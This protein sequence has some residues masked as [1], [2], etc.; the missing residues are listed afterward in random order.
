MGEDART[1]GA[2]LVAAL[3]GYAS[4]LPALERA[5]AADD[6]DGV[7]QA[8]ILVRRLRSLLA[9]SR[10]Y[11]A[12]GAADDVRAHLERLG[13]DLGEVRDLEVRIR[14]AE[15]HVGVG[16]DAAAVERLIV[17]ERARYR[18]AHAGLVEAIAADGSAHDALAAFVGEPPY[19]G[20]AGGPADSSAEAGLRALL[21]AESRRVRRAARRALGDLDSL[22]RLRRAA[23]R[24][25]YVG[26]AVTAGPAAVLGED[27]A[28]LA[29]AA[30][31]VQDVL[32][33]HRDALLF[34][35]QVERAE[36]AARD[37]GEPVDD[38][39]A[40]AASAFRAATERIEALPDAWRS[41]RACADVVA[42][43]ED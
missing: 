37:A 27:A 9:A 23:R 10:P 35:L 3:S 32:G 26:E 4:E 13:D 42:A 12:D 17:R 1:T 19:T 28:A 40:I 33:D 30:K 36:T 22:H 5:A 16:A 8:R 38:Y 41:F 2:A 7:H 39:P 24:L 34:A 29:A 15:E 20:G 43:G 6:P 25:R 21:V 31:D 14:H 18:E 11:F